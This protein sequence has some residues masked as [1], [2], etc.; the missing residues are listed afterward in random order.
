[1]RDTRELYQHLLGLAPP[2][3]V[4]RVK[5]V[6]A[7]QR[8]D[9]W[10][11]HPVGHEWK[12]PRCTHRGSLHDHSDERTWRHLDSCHFG[13]YLHARVPRMR[14]PTHGVLQVAVPWAEPHSRFTL[15]CEGQII[16]TLKQST[17]E[18]TAT[19][20]RLEWGEAM[21]VMQRAVERGLARREQEPLPKRLGIDEKHTSC[22]VLTL[23][24]ELDGKRVYKVLV[25]AK[26]EPLKEY[27]GSFHLAQREAVTA[28][29]MDLSDT[30]YGAVAATIPDSLDKIV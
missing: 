19:L 3:T 14:C 1:M 25:G 15:L 17:V 20:F 29:A 23:V 9:V 18:G 28:V 11:E 27:I 21:R 7:S 13:T 24:N 10:L 4:Q 30:F 12:C 8:I 26:K 5:L 16:A 6:E 2:W 22:G